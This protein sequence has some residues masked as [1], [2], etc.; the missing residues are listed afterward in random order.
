MEKTQKGIYLKERLEFR[1][2]MFMEWAFVDSR[3]IKNIDEFMMETHLI[4][5]EIINLTIEKK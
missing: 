3:I 4:E 1:K 2:R 5:E